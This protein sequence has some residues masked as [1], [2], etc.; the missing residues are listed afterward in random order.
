[1]GEVVRTTLDT[2][3]LKREPFQRM[4][5]AGG[6]NGDAYFVVILA[7]VIVPLLFVLGLVGFD[8]LEWLNWLVGIVA[9]MANA[10]F[11][12]LIA[13]G[14]FWYAATNAL[15]GAGRYHAGLPVVGFAHT[16]LVLIPFISR[17]TPLDSLALVY[18]APA[19][20]AVMIMSVGAQTIYDVPRDK[21]ILAGLAG[22]VGYF[23]AI[24]LFRI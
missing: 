9:G 21:A 1:M 6:S 3:M 16:P 19:A 7:T 8:P 2:A 17:F 4:V 23:I 20:W 11:R 5:F 14:V 13:G 18:L 10:G 24:F 22:A 15:G 12:W